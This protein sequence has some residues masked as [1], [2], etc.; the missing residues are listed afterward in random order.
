MKIGLKEK[1]LQ[2]NQE[3]LDMNNINNKYEKYNLLN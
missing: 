2:L 1:E 3:V